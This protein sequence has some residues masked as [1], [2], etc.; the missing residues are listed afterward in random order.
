MACMYDARLCLQSQIIIST[1]FAT[2]LTCCEITVWRTVS[3]AVEMWMGHRRIIKIFRTES[4]SCFLLGYSSGTICFHTYLCIHVSAYL[5][6]HGLKRKV[7]FGFLFV[8]HRHTTPCY[9]CGS[10]GIDFC[11][12]WLADELMT[13]KVLKGLTIL[14]NMFLQNPCEMAVRLSYS[15]KLV[16]VDPQAPPL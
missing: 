5:C 9:S 7:F 15:V 4:F 11:R 14:Q 3:L 6:I 16:I 13:V 1:S 12:H 10:F 8:A 2:V